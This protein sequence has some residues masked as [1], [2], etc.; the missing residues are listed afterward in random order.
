MFKRTNTILH[1]L[2]KRYFFYFIEG[3]RIDSKVVCENGRRVLEEKCM[4][5][6]H[7]SKVFRK[8]AQ[9]GSFSLLEKKGRKEG[10]ERERKQ[11]SKEVR[12]E[13]RKKEKEKERKK[14]ERKKERKKGRKEGRKKEREKEKES[15]Q[16][17][18]E[19]R[20]REREKERKKEKRK[21]ARKEGRKRERKKK[22]ERERKK[23]QKPK[24]PSK[25]GHCST[26]NV[27]N[28]SSKVRGTRE[29][30]KKAVIGSEDTHMHKR[31]HTHTHAC[32][33]FRNS[34]HMQVK[35]GIEF[36]M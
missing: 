16:A 32:T 25:W 35:V 6:T 30:V 17:R 7:F 26:R 1:V 8:C 33:H 29:V 31:T 12:K 13:G 28:S 9:R 5:Q 10:R 21:Q 11:E 36:G 2:E 3:S 20:K 14:R 24:I 15:K 27:Y 19:E 23:K 34:F 18:K 22:K 4:L